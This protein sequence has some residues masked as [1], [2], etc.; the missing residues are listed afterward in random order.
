[1]KITGSISK[2][3]FILMAICLAA[4]LSLALTRQLTAPRI[5]EQVLQKQ[6]RSLRV[7]LPR[8]RSFSSLQSGGKLDFYRG[9]S[10]SGEVV[11]YAFP[12]AARGYSSEIR[13]MVGIDTR[14]TVTGLKVIEEKETPGLGDEIAH[15][16]C[17]QTL[18]QALA[19]KGDSGEICQPPFMQQY[20]GKKLPEL[21]VVT[22]PAG[23][24]IQ[25]IT[26]ATITS[27]AVTKAV[28]D[29]LETFLREQKISD[30]HE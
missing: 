20:A 10:S 22:G 1:M 8:A 4:G 21:R 6:L 24:E 7:V 14:G 17:N 9:Y 16:P 25:A 5:R 30:K 29:S 23:R 18:W 27:R 13:V 3:G 15:V 19:G 12:G 28:R 26:G 11:G 2:M